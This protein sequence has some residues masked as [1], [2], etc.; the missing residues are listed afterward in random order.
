MIELSTG[1]MLQVNMLINHLSVTDNSLWWRFRIMQGSHG[2]GNVIE[3][4]K[5]WHLIRSQKIHGKQ[6]VMEKLW[7]I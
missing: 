4:V 5:A 3:N 1:V 2:H 6:K 7:K